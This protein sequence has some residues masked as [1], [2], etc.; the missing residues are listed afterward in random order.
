[1]YDSFIGRA[2]MGAYQYKGQFEYAD[3]IALDSEVDLRKLFDDLRKRRRM[4]LLDDRYMT[5][6]AFIEGCDAAAD[7]RLLEGFGEW[8]AEV[9]FNA[10]TTLHWSTIVAAKIDPGLLQEAQARSLS[11]EYE[12]TASSDL[13]ELLDRFLEGKEMA[14]D[15]HAGGN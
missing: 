11:P 7:W 15:D 8:V 10:E 14:D 2:G 5:L 13:L 12:S 9:L 4:F 3:A 1:M 6:V